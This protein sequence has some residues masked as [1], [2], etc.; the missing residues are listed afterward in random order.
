M[1]TWRTTT[2]SPW[3]RRS[4]A[5]DVVE[6]VADRLHLGDGVIELD[7]PRWSDGMRVDQAGQ[8]HLALEIDHW[9]VGPRSFMTS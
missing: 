6:D 8:D 7:H 1:N 2:H 9:V 4:A 5:P 3:P